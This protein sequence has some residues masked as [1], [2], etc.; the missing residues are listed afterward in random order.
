MK[1]VAIWLGTG[2]A[3]SQQPVKNG[4]PQCNDPRESESHPE[5]MTFPRRDPALS[6]EITMALA[7]ASTAAW[8]RRRT[9]GPSQAAPGCLTHRHY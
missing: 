4:G 9:T 1:Q 8:E 6:P 5:P 3:S 2:V 7:K